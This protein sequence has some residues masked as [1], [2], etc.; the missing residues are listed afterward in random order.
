V[1][2]D[3]KG[4]PQFETVEARKNSEGDIILDVRS[5][6]AVQRALQQAGMNTMQT[7][8]RLQNVVQSFKSTVEGSR[9]EVEDYEHKSFPGLKEPSEVLKKEIDAAVTRLPAALQR[10]PAARFIA[11]GSLLVGALTQR[12]KEL[13]AQVSKTQAVVADRKLAGPNSSELT[14]SAAGPST[15]LKMSDFG[16]D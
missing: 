10:N 11:K 9:R 13:E 5:K 1:G 3:A 6:I 8:G 2:Y 16:D 7:A 12:I 14:S 15:D 4:N